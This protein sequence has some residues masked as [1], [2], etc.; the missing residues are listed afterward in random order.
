MEGVSGIR[1]LLHVTC[2]HTAGEGQSWALNPCLSDSKAQA[3]FRVGDEVHRF[4]TV[5]S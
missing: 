5:W 2:G 4:F 3:W 1:E